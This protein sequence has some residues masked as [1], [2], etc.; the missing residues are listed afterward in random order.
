[1]KILLLNWRD[2]KNPDA[3]GAELY[4][5]NLFTN[6]A[7]KNEVYWYCSAFK[8]CK[9]KEKYDNINFIRNGTRV[10]VVF[11]AF[12]H[13]LFNNYDFVV[14][15]YNGVPWGTPMYI[16][17][18]KIG[19]F[20]HKLGDIY[21]KEL[22][23][24]I[25]WFPRF[26]EKR[27]MKLIYKNMKFITIS[28]SSKEDFVKLGLN[29][30][31]I[32]IVNPGVEYHGLKKEEKTKEPTI[33]FVGRLNKYKS[34]PVLIKAMPLVLEKIKNAKLLIVGRGDKEEEL[35]RLVKE[36][37]LENSVKFLGFIPNP[38]LSKIYGSSWVLVNTSLKEGW[39]LT[40]IEASASGT[41]VINSNVPGLKETVK[42]DETG[43]LYEYG[44]VKELSEK[45]IK[46]LIDSKL[47]KR[48]EDNGIKFAKQF[49][50]ER[51][52]EKFGS[53]I[54]NLINN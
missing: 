51:S 28:E 37:K 53:I 25:G 31:K 33:C 8:R 15:A 34:I 9:K 6:L 41:V 16:G 21:L 48:F 45:I 22:G 32:E 20:F 19:I 4:L 39:G 35:K 2:I 3:G 10:T 24:G 52:R 12:F 44:N 46:V 40:A 27:I 5:H 14:E 36:L 11:Y 17:K 1:M 50:W 38:E 49:E 30:N 7:E 26:F 42:D 43:F 54:K 23:R 13:Y 18:K 29:K 47:R